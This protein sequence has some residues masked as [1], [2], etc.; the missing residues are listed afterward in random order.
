MRRRDSSKPLPASQ[1]KSLLLLIPDVVLWSINLLLSPHAHNFKTMTGA[2]ASVIAAS[3]QSVAKV[4]LI[5]AVGFAAVKCKPNDRLLLCASKLP[6][7]LRCWLLTISFAH[8]FSLSLHIDPKSMPLLPRN[9]V[10]TVARFGFH[11]L[12]IPLIYSTIAVSVTIESVGQYWFVL[13]AGF[14]VLAISY[15]VAT[16]MRYLIPIS[17]DEDFDAL[18]IAAT[19]PNIVALPILIFPSLCEYPVVY[20]GF[21]GGTANTGSSQQLQAM[22]VAQSNSMVFLYFFTWSLVFWSV[23]NPQL[24]KAAER[25][26]RE[27]SASLS[28]NLHDMPSSAA[29]VEEE[30]TPST[31]MEVEAV[32]SNATIESGTGDQAHD[33]N[34]S[35]QPSN[36]KRE[37]D[38]SEVNHVSI[39][40]N[41]WHAV[42]QT[43]T[44]PG[45]IAMIAGFVTACIPPLQR[46]LFVEGGPLRFFG[47]AL[48]TLGT[49]SN[50]MSMMVVA[51]SLVPPAP[52][53]AAE[54]SIEEDRSENPMM[55]DPNFG[56]QRRE[57]RISRLTDLRRSS[58][59][60]L[61]AVPRSSPEM[62]RMHLWFNLSR[63]VVSPAVVVGVIMALDCGTGVFANVPGLAKLVVMINAALPGALIV[64]V[65]L[66]SD[67]RLSDT[68]AAVAKV[69]LPNYLLSIVSIAAWT[70]LGLWFTLP[71][72]N[73]STVCRR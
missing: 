44:S 14:F 39:I 22:C 23:G 18:R 67:E 72:K 57:R 51:A 42:K 11:V 25:K 15:F 19:F 59:R 61:H 33:E 49:A 24:M 36:N 65:I 38:S 1:I 47:G 37:G 27:K 55:T 9:V 29:T 34:D 52:E 40:Q 35:S 46:A 4:Y 20:E 53:V 71:D 70:S 58:L 31:M 10:G 73:G 28:A 48:Q 62:R 43:A 60:L 3:A 54:V 64:V 41:I 8:S 13:V 16:L 68:A 21:V 45:F 66:K 26:R 50:P 56:P 12:V 32:P 17:N 69:Y 5:G 7:H 2:I 30:A 6:M 63:L